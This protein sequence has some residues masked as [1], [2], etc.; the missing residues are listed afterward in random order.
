[1]SYTLLSSYPTHQHSVPQNWDITPNSKH[2][3]TTSTW[4]NSHATLSF[5]IRALLVSVPQIHH[6]ICCIDMSLLLFQVHPHKEQELGEHSVQQKYTQQPS[7]LTNCCYTQGPSTNALTF[8]RKAIE[9]WDWESI[10]TKYYAT[11][12]LDHISVYTS[13][14]N[15]MLPFALWVLLSNL[16]PGC[17]VPCEF[18]GHIWWPQGLEKLDG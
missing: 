13:N 15:M 4:L 3:S 10:T 16:G 1:M 9:C 14:D 12:L 5:K 11:K 7:L 2:Y 8:C 17:L 6:N 18:R